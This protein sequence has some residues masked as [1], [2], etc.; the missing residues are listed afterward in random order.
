M[1]DTRRHD[2][3]PVPRGY[4][5]TG[6]VRSSNA[7]VG[8]DYVPT[9]SSHPSEGSSAHYPRTSSAFSRDSNGYYSA[10]PEMPRT[11]TGYT[12]TASGSRFSRQGNY[13]RSSESGSFSSQGA[14]NPYLG[15]GSGGRGS[16]S[17]GVP[18]HHG[19]SPRRQGNKGAIIALVV[20][21]VLAAGG[22]YLFLNPPFFNVTIN[23]DTHQVK[24]GTT[25]AEAITAG[26]ATPTAG[27]L[28]AVDGSLLTEGGG[29][30]F[31]ATLSDGSTTSDGTQRLSKDQT[32]TIDNGVDA[33]ESSTTTTEEVPFQTNTDISASD[34]YKGALHVYTTGQNGER[35]TKKGDV[36]GITVTEDT[37]PVQNAGLTIGNAKV[38]GEKVVALTFDDGPW[39]TTNDLLDVLEANGAKATFFTIGNQISE[40]PDAVKRA[41]SMGCQICS[42]TWDHAAGSGQGVNITYM[43]ADEQTEEVN[44]GF[45]AIDDLLGTKV[46]RVFRA[47]GGNFYGSAVSNLQPLITAEIGWDID[48]EDWRRPGADA[49]ASQILKASPGSVI[50]MH[51]GG[52]DRTQTIE[53]LKTALPQL[54][55]EGYRFVT[56]DELLAYGVE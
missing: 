25:I 21:L 56:I 2:G 26:Y 15:G 49:I 55:S 45:G 38:N 6:H 13:V 36:S 50:L 29:T 4:R 16:G 31:T 28:M 22:V 19:S 9:G 23:G 33:E 39:K 51:D 18:S 34:Y 5:P 53:A 32:L 1:G 43:T 3:R 14:H 41:S 27:N 42:H 24:S 30:A 17:H 40:Y 37:K 10:G 8:D 12:S 7:Y 48:T 52:G 20:L 44:K 46:S 54:V 47:P 35:T 11:T